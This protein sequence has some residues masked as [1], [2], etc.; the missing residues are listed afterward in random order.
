MSCGVGHRHGL[1]PKFLWLWCR[2]AATAPIQPLAWELTHASGVAL[3]SKKQIKQK[4]NQSSHGG[5]VVMKLT[6]IHE[7]AGM[8]PGLTQD[9]K[10]PTLL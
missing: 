3:K 4:Q 2:L 10:D 1:D 5:V 8:I 7:D 9:V 6:G